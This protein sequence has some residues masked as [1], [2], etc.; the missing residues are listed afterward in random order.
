MQCSVV[1]SVWLLASRCGISQG[2]VIL[3]AGMFAVMKRNELGAGVLGMTLSYT[4]TIT[5]LLNGLIRI[6]TELE[7][8]FTSVERI[9]EYHSVDQE[10]STHAYEPPPGWPSKGEVRCLCLAGGQECH[11]WRQGVWGCFL[12]AA[13]AAEDGL[14]A[15]RESAPH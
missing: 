3:A 4:F 5:S 14:L 11:T 13:R 10:A 9:S 7:N 8:C 15:V 2:A 1:C 6:F 12:R